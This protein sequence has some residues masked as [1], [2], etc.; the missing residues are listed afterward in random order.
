MNILCKILGLLVID[1]G[2]IWLIVFQIDPDPSISIEVIFLVPCI[3]LIN[4]VISGILL[5]P[6]KNEL[7]KIFALNSI[8]A[9]FLMYYLFGEGINRHQ[10]KILESW[11]FQKADTA[12]MLTRWKNTNEFR[13]SYSLSQGS[14]FDFLE[15]KCVKEGRGWVLKSDSI[16]MTIVDKKLIGFKKSTEPIEME[17]VER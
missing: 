13:L 4:L 17:K 3:F 11:R 15:G 12:Y 5:L 7:S 2:L 9:S 14:S 16:E 8:I 10:D 6:Q 1:F